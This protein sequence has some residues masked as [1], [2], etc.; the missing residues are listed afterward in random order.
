M[1]AAT[2]GVIDD[3]RARQ[4]RRLMGV[5]TIIVCAGI[6][7]GLIVGRSESPD[8]SRRAGVAIAVAP[9]TVLSQTPYMGVAC[10]IANSTTCDRVGLAVWL[11]HPARS[12]SAAIA[13]RTLRL[14]WAGDRP[15]RF[16]S[17]APRTEFD[18]FLQPAGIVARLHAAA[19]PPPLRW[20]TSSPANSPTPMV[21]LRIE[22]VDGRVSVT[23][24][25]VP[26]GSGWG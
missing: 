16:A 26:L 21:Q 25:R 22:W 7:A 4:R 2:F 6:A 14:D 18:G 23:R 17:H 3:A 20:W 13:G 10:P 5:A 11:R 8:A 9:A 15:P 12:V 24:L 19:G 1:H